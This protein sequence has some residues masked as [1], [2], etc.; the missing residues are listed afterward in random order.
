MA[1]RAANLTVGEIGGAGATR[2]ASVRLAEGL[3]RGLEAW[4]QAAPAG[5]RPGEGLDV[6]ATP[7]GV[8]KCKGSGNKHGPKGPLVTTNFEIVTLGNQ[9]QTKHD[10]AD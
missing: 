7:S 5:L 10:D 8:L 4:P 2:N 1:A 9:S 6:C 3:G